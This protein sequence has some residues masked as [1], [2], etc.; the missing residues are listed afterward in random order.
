MNPPDDPPPFL[1]SWKKVYTFVLIYVA[2]LIYLLYVFAVA[3][4]P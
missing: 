3:T 4:A 1:G 2:A